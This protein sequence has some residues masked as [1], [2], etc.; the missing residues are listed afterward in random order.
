MSWFH[1]LET[2][3]GTGKKREVFEVRCDAPGCYRTT[4]VGRHGGNPAKVQALL[5][6]RQWTNSS[7]VDGAKDFCPDHPAKAVA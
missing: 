3:L 7:V 5:F 4:V 1:A 2:H 6:K